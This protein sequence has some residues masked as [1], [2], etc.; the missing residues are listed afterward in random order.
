MRSQADE[1]G[2]DNYLKPPAAINKKKLEVT[3]EDRL[4]STSSGSF[5]QVRLAVAH[6]VRYKLTRSPWLSNNPANYHVRL[7]CRPFVP[8][9]L[10]PICHRTGPS[11]SSAT[12]LPA[13]ISFLT[14]PYRA[15]ISKPSSTKSQQRCT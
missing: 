2:F 10:R 8:H 4:F 9:S 15:S 3:N 14:P 13:H 6:G 1:K 7:S 11:P 5:A 12:P